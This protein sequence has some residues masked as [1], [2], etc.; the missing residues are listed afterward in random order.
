MLEIA[1]ARLLEKD[2]GYWAWCSIAGK[3]S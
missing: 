3:R 1:M 2:H